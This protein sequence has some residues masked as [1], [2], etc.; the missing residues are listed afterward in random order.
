MS[1]AQR[2]QALLDCAVLQ[3][4]HDK[5]NVIIPAGID[6]SIEVRAYKRCLKIA[7]EEEAKSAERVLQAE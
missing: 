4:T 6:T 3:P 5:A 1:T 7:Q 2:I